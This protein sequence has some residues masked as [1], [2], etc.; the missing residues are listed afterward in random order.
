MSASAEQPADVCRECGDRCGSTW[1]TV[2]VGGRVEWVGECGVS[3][4]ARLGEAAAPGPDWIAQ[5][6]ANPGAGLVAIDWTAPP[7]AA[8]LRALELERRAD[9]ID[10]LLDEHGAVT[11]AAL[12]EALSC[13]EHVARATLRRALADGSLKRVRCG[14]Y[15]ASGVDEAATVPAEAPEGSDEPGGWKYGALKRAVLDAI[16]SGARSP[17]D[18]C[19]ATGASK[20]SVDQALA[21]AVETGDI[22]RVRR[23]VYAL[24]GGR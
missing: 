1:R 11:I 23:G 4:R 21:R 12:R 22:V 5:G 6:R 13:S 14:V 7:E 10:A 9:A 8:E 17:A 20:S 24:A 18:V 2:R 19:G 16:A 3:I 15:N